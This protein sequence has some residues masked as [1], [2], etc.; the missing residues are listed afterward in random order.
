VI[1][2]IKSFRLRFSTIFINPLLCGSPMAPKSAAVVVKK[3]RW[4]QI[5][6]PKLFSEQII[7]ESFVGEPQELVGRSVSV[8]LMVLTGDPQKQATSMSFKITGVQNDRVSTELVGLKVLP[9]A[10]KK[11]MRR[12]RSKIDDSF[13]VQ[14]LDKK[15]VRIK[16][17]IIARG[18]TT[19]NVMASM[20]RLERAFVARTVAKLDF[21]NFVRDVVTKKFQQGLG[22]TLRKL[23]PIGACEVRQFELISAE[24]V[25]EMGIKVMAVPESLPEVH[26][27]G[28]PK[29]E[30]QSQVKAPQEVQK[31]EAPQEAQDESSETTA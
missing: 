9:A 11:L 3:K 12:K 19:G 14:T 27:K 7:G 8:S 29:D 15:V 23:Y 10:A 4:V 16:P 1:C 28:E 5:V 26:S 31:E 2:S 6:A 21:E 13:V 30:D 20:Q 17:M 22:Q 24:K 25:K 18:K